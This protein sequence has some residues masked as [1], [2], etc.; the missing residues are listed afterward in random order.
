MCNQ[1]HFLKRSC[2]LTVSAILAIPLLLSMAISTAM[3]DN[4]ISSGTTFKVLSGTTVFSSEGLVIKSGATLDNA[5]T[6]ILKKNLANENVT[7]NSL[8]SG[9][10]EFS[11]TV[12]QTI[13]G[14]NIIQNLTVNNVTGVTIGDNTTVN[15][16]LNL[17][18]GTITLGSD[19]L[20]LGQLA[21][22]A[23]TPSASN[24]IIVTETG[25]LRKEFQSGFTGSFTFPVG[26]DNG[27][28]EY[29]PVTLNF[30][31][32]SFAAGNY[33]GVSLKNEKYPDD[34]I[35]GNYLKR[36]WT[37]TQSGI[38]GFTCNATF[39]YVTEDVTGNE[40]V[41]S[42]TKVNP[43]PWIT[44]G[45]TDAIAHQLAATGITTFSSFTGLKSTTPPVN[46]ELVN[47]TIPD[48]VTNCYDA[49]Q[50]LTVAGNGNTFIVENNGSV[51]LV[52]GNKI[53]MLAGTKVNSGGYLLGRITTSGNY[54]GATFNPLVANNQDG[55]MLGIETVAKYQFFKVYPNPTNDIIIVELMG[56][57]ATTTANITVYN[58][59]GEKLLQ[60][61]LTCESI[62]QF[63]LSGKP[64]G[65]YMVHVQSGERSE[66]AKVIKN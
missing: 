19:N 6:L 33:V 23:G 29:S 58:L 4:V 64:V 35:T 20:L 30:T 1:H 14:Q 17:T 55:E 37:I 36:Y 9:T 3:A 31:G 59:Q 65:I 12:N 8:G 63:S 49:T 61:S 51:T 25:Q 10:A 15:G 50:V 7:P 5:G 41:I 38:T 48:G 46:Q 43:A 52:A 21:S 18:N 27:T 26:D 42:C 60:K 45:L 40:N 54:C 28:S 16:V 44:Y 13:G 34:N 57:V 24:M 11:G 2:K 22:I 47:I 56:S 32:G 62:L 66:I 39:Q 53:L